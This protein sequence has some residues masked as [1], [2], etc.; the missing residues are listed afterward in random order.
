MSFTGCK[1]VRD[2]TVHWW[3]A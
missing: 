2:R 3:W 1:V